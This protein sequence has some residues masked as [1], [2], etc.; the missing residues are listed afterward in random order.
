M[1]ESAVLL[2]T[3]VSILLVLVCI[4]LLILT[5]RDWF[6]T[7]RQKKWWNEHGFI[8]KNGWYNHDYFHVVDGEVK[9]K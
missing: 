8:H 1:I 5:I 9:Q 4:Y 6:E 7:R 2:L 3:K